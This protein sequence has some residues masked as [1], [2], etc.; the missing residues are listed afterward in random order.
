MLVATTAVLVASV[1]AQ[2]LRLLPSVMLLVAPFVA[3]AAVLRLR[4]VATPDHLV[5]HTGWRRRTVAWSDVR[6]RFLPVANGG[7][8]ITSRAEVH[9]IRDALQRCRDEHLDSDRSRVT[10]H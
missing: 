7:F 6:T 1:L 3:V 4:V 9:A 5:V 2:G 10:T 8:P